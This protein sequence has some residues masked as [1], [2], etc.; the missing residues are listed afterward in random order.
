[1]QFT[2]AQWA[3]LEKVFPSG[4]CDW[5]KPGVSQAPTVPWLN[6]EGKVGG[7]P[8]GPAPHSTPLG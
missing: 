5:S 2:D 7:Q 1:V 3:T 4:V 8:L 6:Y